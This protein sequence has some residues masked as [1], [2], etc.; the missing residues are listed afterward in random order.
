MIA[1]GHA[2]RGNPMSY[3]SMRHPMFAIAL[4]IVSTAGGDTCQAQTNNWALETITDPTAA[5]WATVALDTHSGTTYS[6]F[7]G[8][9]GLFA[10]MNEILDLSGPPPSPVRQAPTKSRVDMTRVRGPTI[11]SASTRGTD[12]FGKH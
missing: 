10:A 11:W 7:G 2:A 1:G 9:P 8:A 12:K 5:L 4:T 6:T 3:R